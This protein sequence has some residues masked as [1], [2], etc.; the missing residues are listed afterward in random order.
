[1]P[2]LDLAVGAGERQRP[3]DRAPVVVLLDQAAGVFFGFRK[4]GDEGD[5]GRAAG[6]QPHELTQRDDRIEH[7]PGRVRQRV[8]RSPA[9]SDRVERAAAPTKRA[10]EDSRWIAVQRAALRVSGSAPSTAG[11][12]PWVRGRR[13]ADEPLRLRQPFHL[14]EHTAE[15]A[16]RDVGC[17]RREHD[18]GVRGDLDL[19]RL[20]AVVR[21]R[22]GAPRFDRVLG[23]DHDLGQRLQA[24]SS[25]RWI[26]DAVDGEGGS[27]R[28]GTSGQGARVAEEPEDHVR[29]AVRRCARRGRRPRR[30]AGRVLAVAADV[31]GPRQVSMPVPASVTTT[32]SR[33]RRA[34]AGARRGRVGSGR[35]PTLSTRESA[36]ILGGAGARGVE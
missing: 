23:G 36:T 1:M 25:V 22:E 19:A 12:L 8:R 2:Q 35:S 15:R 13:V 20:L 21:D 18:L 3:G 17:A 4:A 6:R 16:V 5:A 30:R 26:F 14:D 24:S 29:P 28:R 10:R 33:A 31:Q 32:R 9:R 34:R 11:G 7:R 27:G